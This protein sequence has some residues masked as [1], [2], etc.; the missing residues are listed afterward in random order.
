LVLLCCILSI[1]AISPAFGAGQDVSEALAEFAEDE[2]NGLVL[3]YSDQCPDCIRQLED[4]EQFLNIYP[5]KTF[6]EINLAQGDQDPQRYRIQAEFA[7]ENNVDTVPQLHL[8]INRG[9][10]IDR[11]VVF[12]GYTPLPAIERMLIHLLDPGFG[13][14]LFA[15]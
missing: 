5:W 6:R 12:K 10:D 2:N 9:D 1:T 13:A 4:I 11:Y 8:F 14:E 3:F 7:L 15:K